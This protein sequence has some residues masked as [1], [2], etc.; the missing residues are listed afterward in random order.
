M[1]GTERSLLCRPVYRL[2]GLV[3]KYGER[4]VCRIDN[5]EIQRGSV[6]AI[7]GP[8]G[9]GKSTLLRMMGFLEQPTAGDILFEGHRCSNGT[10]PPI[11]LRRRITMVLQT[12][13][14][15]HGSVERNVAYGLA[16]R[17]QRNYSTRVEEVLEA[18]GLA[19]LAKA[20]AATLSGGEAQRVA[21]ARALAFSPEVLL[22]DEPTANLDPA[23]VGLVEKLIAGAVRDLKTTVVLVTQNLFQAE[24]LADQVTLMLD[25]ELIEVGTPDKMFNHP[26]DPR[27]RAFLS[28]EMVY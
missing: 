8:N 28:G 2:E 21:F 3:K 20:K 23:G 5:L 17:G 25:G 4:E 15:F 13:A 14:L 7:M 18:V 26:E 19:H 6:T 1:T 16:I 24:R 10:E 11:S 12:P 9:A 27:T 22:L